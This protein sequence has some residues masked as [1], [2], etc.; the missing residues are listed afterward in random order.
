MKIAKRM[1]PILLVPFLAILL[2]FDDAF[3]Q[4]APY[5]MKVAYFQGTQRFPLYVM[6]K[7]NL[8]KKYNIDVERIEVQSVA[9]LYT[10]M[11]AKKVDI[12][13]SGWTAAALF[14][15]RGVDLLIVH[16]VSINNNEVL[17]HGDSNIQSLSDLRGKKIGNYAGPA[18]A[19]TAL[20]KTI[21]KD[22]YSIDLEKESKFHYGAPAA[23][24]ALFEKRELE[25]SLTMDPWTAKFLMSG[26]FRSV[27]RLDNE[28]VKRGIFPILLVTV[29]TNEEYANKNPEAV[30]NFI[31]AYR[32]AVNYMKT[33]DEIWVELAKSVD[34]ETKEGV[35]ILK[36]RLSYLFITEWD[37]KVISAHK[38][39]AKREIRVMGPEYLP[40]FPDGIMTTKFLPKD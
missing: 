14:R 21:A 20:L 38:E 28:C 7:L 11:T 34:V 40:Y 2:L 39:F 16:P 1:L 32:E 31:R 36:D 25:A 5:K 33:N 37:N 26:K 24:A 10:L 35:K 15:T 4:K 17:V 12:S 23:I 8:W 19:S 29:V 22:F 6:D 13:F 30:T 3:A 9:I 27:A 18:G